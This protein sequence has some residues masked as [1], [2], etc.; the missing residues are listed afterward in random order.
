MRAG[1]ILCF[2]IM[3]TVAPPILAQ[4]AVPVATGEWAPFTSKELPEQGVITALVRDV[5]ARIGREPDIVFYP[6]KRCY[7]LVLSGRVWGAFPYSWTQGR[8]KEVLFSDPI[9][10]SDTGWFYVG[11]APLPAYRELQDLQELRIGGVVGYFYKEALDGAG[12]DVVYAPDEVSALRMLLAGRI[13]LVP[14]NILV[15]R[16]IIDTHFPGQEE[17]I[18]LLDGLYSRNDLRMIVS[19]AYPGARELLEAFNAALAQAGVEPPSNE[20]TPPAQ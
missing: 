19:H 1:I 17:K 3:L 20:P 5:F 9:G 2:A 13:D 11:V 4:E 8:A 10:Y 12:L 6:W 14:M 16:S 7:D 18:K 15:A